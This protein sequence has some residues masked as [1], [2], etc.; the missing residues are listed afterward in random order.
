MRERVVSALRWQWFLPTELSDDV[1]QLFGIATAF[2]GA[3]VV[4]LKLTCELWF[5]H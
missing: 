5:K 1:F 2:H 3:F 4:F